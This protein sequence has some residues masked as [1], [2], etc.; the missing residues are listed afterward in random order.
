M[1]DVARVGL[2]SDLH[3]PLQ[4]DSLPPPLA[5]RI[6]ELEERVKALEARL[7]TAGTVTHGVAFTWDGTPYTTT[8]PPAWP[9]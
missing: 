8:H 4:R 1:P 5:R 6:A 2:M 7:S 9:L 3:P